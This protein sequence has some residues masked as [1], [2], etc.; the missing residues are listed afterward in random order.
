[1]KP[2]HYDEYVKNENKILRIFE[3]IGQVL[4]ACIVLVFKEFNIKKGSFWIIW[5]ILSFAFMMLYEIYW[6]KY[7]KSEKNMSD[8][9]SSLLGI[10]V[11][12]ATLPVIAFFLLGIYGKNILLIIA[13]VI[14]G[15]GHI[16]IHIGHKKELQ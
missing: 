3:N 2:A 13:A 6:I 9:Y 5:L 11:A 10:P 8:F 12:G 4:V 14:L 16:G 7:F 15:I 1:N